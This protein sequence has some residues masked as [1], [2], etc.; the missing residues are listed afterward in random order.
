MN[1][2]LSIGIYVLM[3]F[4]TMLMTGWC[5]NSTFV[6]L[7]I[8]KNRPAHIIVV[9]LYLLVFLLPI[10]GAMLPNSR[11]KFD[12][13]GAG[14]IWLGFYIYYGA[15]LLFLWIVAFIVQK[16]SSKENHMIRGLVLTISFITA[17]VVCVHGLIHAQQTIVTKLDIPI[18]KKAGD[19]KE[20]NVILLGD[21]HLSVNSY[22][23]TTKKMVD[24]INKE[25]PDVVVIAGDIFTSTYEGLRHP[26]RYAEVLRK[27]KSRYGV[28]AVYGNHDVEETLFGGFPITPISQAYRTKQ[29]EQFFKD[30]NFK[31]LYDNTALIADDQV[32]IVGRV[33][34]EK[35]GDGTAKRKSASEV[36]Q[37]VDQTKPV[38]VL[39]HEPIEFK[40]LKDHGADLAMCG[41]TH[42]GQMFPGNMIVPFFNENAYGYKLIGGLDTVVTSGVGYYGPPMRI[43]T[44]SEIMVL[45][46][47]FQ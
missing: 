34:G 23:P 10:L 6:P 11:L 40:D 19:H 31:V 46:L 26:A 2:I 18:E 42:A 25:D 41:H 28:Y 9:T 27:I 20:L 5:L 30:C 13:Q 22:F 4:V 8:R 21:L 16:I 45:H 35:A 32:Q 37:N 14:N 12:L 39:E 3:S 47:S 15:I 43:G 7:S 36:L 44:D 1:P 24:M 17:L 38:L 33:D 29:M